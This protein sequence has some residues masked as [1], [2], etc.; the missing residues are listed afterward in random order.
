M[1]KK[2]LIR[3]TIL[4][5]LACAFLLSSCAPKFNP[6]DPPWDNCYGSKG[7]HPCDFTLKDQD[8]KDVQLYD[9]YGKVIVLDFSTMWCG[10][11]QMAALSIDDTIKKFGKENVVYIT[12]L[13]E[14]SFG[15]DPD[16]RDL[17]N[18]VK[19]NGITLG[20]V[21]AGSK[22]FLESSEFGIVGWPTF[23]FIDQGMVLQGVLT[24]Y[25]GYTIDHNI[26][27]L[28]EQPDTGN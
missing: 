25:N 21:L 24:G 11:C 19:Q 10:P 9:Y 2:Y 7:E 14:N 17:Q 13:V 20:P 4:A 26:A 8:G 23:F 1:K 12:I 5:L 27:K 22:E 15:K 6:E 18:W 28:L 3:L 16:Q